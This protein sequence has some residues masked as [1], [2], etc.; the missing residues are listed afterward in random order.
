MGETGCW[1]PRSKPGKGRPAWQENMRRI[2]QELYVKWLIELTGDD[3]MHLARYGTDVESAGGN[4][5]EW[6]FC[7]GKSTLQVAFAVVEE[8]FHQIREQVVDF[9]NP[10]LRP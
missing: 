5:V 1:K 3:G 10:Y 7:Q 2:L 8:I 6:S 4:V 9:G